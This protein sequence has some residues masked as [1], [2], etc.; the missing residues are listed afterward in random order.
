M[1]PRTVARLAQQLRLVSVAMCL[2]PA[3][4]RVAQL[5]RL[6]GTGGVVLQAA[7]V[8]RAGLVKVRESAALTSVGW[9]HKAPSASPRGRLPH[10]EAGVSALV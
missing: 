2:R 3:H 9:Q 5:D 4:V 8:R 1:F 10:W 6:T 7:W